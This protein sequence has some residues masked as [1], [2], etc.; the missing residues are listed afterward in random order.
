[1]IFYFS[2]TGNSQYVAE[3]LAKVYNDETYYM[4]ECLHQNKLAY[5]LQKDEPLGI[6]CPTY[7]LALPSIVETFL[8]KI[9]IEADSSSKPYIYFVAT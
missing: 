4:A 7:C 9:Q 2:A 3:R 5:K 1:M 6:V 8:D